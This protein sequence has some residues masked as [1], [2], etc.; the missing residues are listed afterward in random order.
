MSKTG[1]PVLKHETLKGSG[2][3][4]SEGPVD[5]AIEDGSLTNV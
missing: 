5:I 3:R 1:K 2:W 4:T